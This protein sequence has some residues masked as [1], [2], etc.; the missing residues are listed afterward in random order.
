M[1]K[2]PAHVWRVPTHVWEVS[3]HV[4]GVPAHVWEVTDHVWKVSAHVWE[5]TAHMW[6]S[7]CMCGGPYSCV[8]GP[9]SCVG[10]PY[11]RVGVSGPD[12][13]YTYLCPRKSELS[14]LVSE[15][16]LECSVWELICALY[17]DRLEVERMDELDSDVGEVGPCGV[18]L[19]NVII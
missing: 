8:G 18:A 2:V 9:C 4:W 14:H 3:A 5:I 15:L 7:L 19:A 10:G 1:W 13:S 12:I 11:S 6:G 16:K 17:T